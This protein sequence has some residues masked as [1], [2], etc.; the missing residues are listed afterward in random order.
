MKKKSSLIKML[1]SSDRYTIIIK[2]IIMTSTINR[3]PIMVD[4]IKFIIYI[5]KVTTRTYVYK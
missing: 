4:I 5:I 3:K 2:K 1:Y